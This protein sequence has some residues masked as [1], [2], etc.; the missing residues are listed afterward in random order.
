MEK[1]EYGYKTFKQ[2]IEHLKKLEYE[3]VED[4]FLGEAFKFAERR[5]EL[6]MLAHINSKI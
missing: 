6:E 4:G 5:H 2:V 3:S 1:K